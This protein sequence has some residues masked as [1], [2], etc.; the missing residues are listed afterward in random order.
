MSDTKQTQ[1]IDLSAFTGAC[2]LLI[3]APLKVAPGTNGRFQPT[4][5]PDLGPALYK[6]VRDLEEKDGDKSKKVQRTVNI[7]FSDTAAALGNWLEEACLSG[8]DYNTDCQGIPYV[9]VLDGDASGELKP[10]LTSSVREP[11]RLASPYVLSAER[12]G[13]QE[14]MKDWL[15]KPEQLAV[16]KQRPVRPWV[17]AQKL[18]DIDPGCILHGVFLE[19]LDGRLRLTRLL[20]GFIEAANPNQVN[21]GGV[22]RGEISAKDNIPFAKQE[23]TSED[24]QASFILHLSTLANHNLSEPQNRFLILWS[25]YKI[26]TL[27][28]RCLRLRSGCEFK[29]LRVEP[30]LDD[31]MWPWPST[32]DIKADFASAKDACFPKIQDP[33]SWKQRRVT[34]ATWSEPI[35]PTIVARPDGVTAEMIR[36]EGFEGRVEVVQEQEFKSGKG[37]D[38]KTEKKPALVIRGM[39]ESK[40][41]DYEELNELLTLN[42]DKIPDG[43]GEKDNLAHA[44]VKDAVNAHRKKLK[45]RD[46]KQSKKENPEQ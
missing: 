33:N 25:L 37:K 5:F 15:K 17:L 40:D 11:H 26:D 44:V 42:P 21:Y 29:L 34:V 8:D 9:R 24:I 46:K 1:K 36:V 18:F 3:N 30:L 39:W 16:N 22:Y 23:F 28:H 38:R 13:G 43:E 45:D 10:F 35:P 31:K 2:R 27:L 14:T 20:S 32:E 19:E 12:D 4:G 41:N 6:G 7:L